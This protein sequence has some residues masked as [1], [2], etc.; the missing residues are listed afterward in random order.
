MKIIKRSG[1]EVD[2]DLQ[3][4]I[5][6]M[7]K[8]NKSVEPNLRLDEDKIVSMAKKVERQAKKVQRTLNVEEI[9]DMVENELMASGAF[10]VVILPSASYS[11]SQTFKLRKWFL[12]PEGTLS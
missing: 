2:F 5:V 3:K 7:Q 4:I 1:V 10:A 8:A 6:A 9:Q 11:N 12:P